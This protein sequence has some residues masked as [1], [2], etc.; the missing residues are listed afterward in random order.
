MTE[1]KTLVERYTEGF[2]RGDLPQILSCLADDVVWELH[3]SKTLVGKQAFAAE[4]D[5]GGTPNPELTL[6][7]LVEEGDAVA[8][9]GHGSVVLG[10]GDPVQFEYAEVF[11]FT[12]G[13]FSRPDTF[14]V[15]LGDLTARSEPQAPSRHAHDA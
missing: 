1:Q 5:S 4:A 11:T 9:V 14:H 8:V 6:D 2:R 15:W 3:G 10:H 12:D 7:R 13:F